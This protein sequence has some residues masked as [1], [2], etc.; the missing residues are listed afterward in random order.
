MIFFACLVFVS[1]LYLNKKDRYGDDLPD[2]FLDHN[3]RASHHIS[4]LISIVKRYD[5]DFKHK[6]DD[7]DYMRYG[8]FIDIEDTCAPKMPLHIPPP[9]D[10]MD[11]DY[12]RSN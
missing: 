11:L 1:F 12:S 4:E 2:D 8:R 9:E 3:D 7:L 6:M 10:I 5:P